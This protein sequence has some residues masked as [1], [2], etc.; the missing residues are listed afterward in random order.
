MKSEKVWMSL[1]FTFSLL[2]FTFAANAAV[3]PPEGYRRIG[4]IESTKGGEQYI[5]TLV[6]VV[7]NALNVKDPNMQDAKDQIILEFLNDTDKKYLDLCGVEKP[8]ALGARG[9]PRLVDVAAE[10][11]TG[12]AELARRAFRRGC[13]VLRQQVQINEQR[14]ARKGGEGRIGA[15]AVAGGTQR[16]QLPAAL[17]R[18]A[19]KVDEAVRRLPHRADAAVGR[20]RAQGQ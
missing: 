5:K 8:A 17:L 2:L 7:P 15:V 3:E 11:R 10:E 12:E 6:E 13:A 20:Q 1:L 16:Q 9:F 19:Q 4:W 14:I 18:L